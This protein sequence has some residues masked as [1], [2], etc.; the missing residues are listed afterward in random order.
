M[1]KTAFSAGG[2][3]SFVSVTVVLIL[4]KSDLYGN[5]YIADSTTACNFQAAT[6]RV[7]SPDIVSYTD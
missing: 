3:S 6:I 5:Y 1:N 7:R 2:K 4:V